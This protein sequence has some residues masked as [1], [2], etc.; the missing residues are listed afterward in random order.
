MARRKR[1]SRRG[2]ASASCRRKRNPAELSESWANGIVS[3]DARLIASN[4]RKMRRAKH[5]QAQDWTLLEQSARRID[6]L[7]SR[8][9]S[10][11]RLGVHRNPK[12]GGH[13]HLAKAG[14]LL[15]FTVKRGARAVGVVTARTAVAAAKEAKA[16][17]L[18]LGG[19]VRAEFCRNPPRGAVLSQR[20]EAITYKHAEDGD[21]YRHR[22]SPGVVVKVSPDRK[23]VKLYRPD[24]KPLADQFDV[25]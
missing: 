23:S 20:A 22:F 19:E 1:A 11:A 21:W 14:K 9:A 3:A 8:L 25:P 5:I 2:S 18:K 10:Q 7:A 4:V 15:A 24:G 16:A 17:G 6:D 12:K 13:P